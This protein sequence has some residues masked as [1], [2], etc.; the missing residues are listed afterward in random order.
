VL[1]PAGE[2]FVEA[3]GFGLAGAERDF[4]CPR[5]AALKAVAGD[6]GVGVD[7][8]GDDAAR[9]EA[10]SASVQGGVRPV[11]LQGSRVT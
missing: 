5:R 3:A 8:G 10:M 4:E 2:A 7:G 1:A 6:G 11:W 9:P